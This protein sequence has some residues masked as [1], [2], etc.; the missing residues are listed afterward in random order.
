MRVEFNGTGFHAEMNQSEDARNSNSVSPALF[1]QNEKP[2]F[3]G[4]IALVV[5]MINLPFGIF[6]NLSTEAIT[7]IFESS[8][9]QWIAVLCVISCVIICASITLGILSICYFSKSK[10]NSNDVVGLA[11]AIF[12]FAICVIGVVLNIAGVFY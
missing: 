10:K 12:S 2:L 11:V 1:F 4:L 7:K 3:F 5:A 6:M 8:A 9:S